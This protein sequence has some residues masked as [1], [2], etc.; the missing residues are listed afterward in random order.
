M[1]R[2]AR[3]KV[4]L[5]SLIVSRLR[6]FPL[7]CFCI[8]VDFFPIVIFLLHGLVISWRMN[9]E[10]RK[11][12]IYFLNW[13]VLIAW[14]VKGTTLSDSYHHFP[15]NIIFVLPSFSSY[16]YFTLLYHYFPYHHFTL[17]SF[18]FYYHFPL[19]IIFLLPSFSFLTPF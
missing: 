10:W 15:I 17:P 19:I 2:L 7:H 9:K 6:N 1:D 18:S 14:G 8:A 13:V 3:L 4:K 16:H 11:T 5:I 12:Y